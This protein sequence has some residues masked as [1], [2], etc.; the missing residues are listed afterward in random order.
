MELEQGTK[1]LRQEPREP[2][3]KVDGLVVVLAF[4]YSFFMCRTLGDALPAHHACRPRGRRKPSRETLYV[5][6]RAAAQHGDARALV[7]ADGARALTRDLAVAASGG[8]HG[9]LV[10]LW[11]SCF[12]ESAD[13]V[14]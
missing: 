5:D 1:K 14:G 12:A 10:V 11:T 6:R 7:E 3:L 2:L 13:D 8:G 9:C 4:L